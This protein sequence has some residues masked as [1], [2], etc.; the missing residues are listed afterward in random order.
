MIQK[1]LPC[2]F[3]RWRKRGREVTSRE[4][5]REREIER[6]AER[7]WRQISGHLHKPVMEM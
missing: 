1:R 6:E 3:M 4:T 2:I 5:E 7:L